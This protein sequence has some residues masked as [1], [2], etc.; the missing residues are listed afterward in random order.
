[1]DLSAQGCCHGILRKGDRSGLVSSRVL[2][3]DTE[4]RREKWICQLKGVV[5][6]YLGKEREVA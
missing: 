4:E 6:G 5:T 2:S 1:V 3:R